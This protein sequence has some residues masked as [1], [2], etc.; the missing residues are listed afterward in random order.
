M[1]RSSG[2]T[3]GEFSVDRSRPSSAHYC[4]PPLDAAPLEER[5]RRL[6][7]REMEFERRCRQ[8]ERQRELAEQQ[9]T[10]RL[11]ALSRREQQLFLQEEALGS[12]RL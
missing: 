11:A 5:E 4:P 3:R 1:H 7:Q 9:Y 2:S 6:R 12:R 10:A 8:W